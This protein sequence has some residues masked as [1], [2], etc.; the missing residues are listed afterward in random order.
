MRRRALPVAL[1]LAAWALT[2]KP[3]VADAQTCERPDFLEAIP[4]DGATDV[5]PNA[6]LFARY[7]TSAEYRD[8]DI[9]L[10]HVGGETTLLG[11]EYSPSEG[12]LSVTPELLA[13]GEYRVKWPEL[14]GRGG[15]ATFTVGDRLDT[16]APRFTGILDVTWDVQRRRDSCTDSV[17]DRYVFDLGLGAATDDGGT[18]LLRLVVFQTDGPGIGGAKPVLTQAFPEDDRVRVTL[19]VR[20]GTGRI[21]FAAVVL[22]ALDRASASGDRQTC[23]DTVAPPFFYGCRL[24][25]GKRAPPPG[26][27][28]LGLLALCA[29]RRRP[30]TRT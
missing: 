9:E 30:S 10:A 7:R 28:L 3:G 25:S 29:A 18:D 16:D 24:A 12:L 19:G 21:C 15:E 6:R 1:A 17:E 22:D 2:Q 26:V 8:E 20:E 27:L 14:R 5:P 4:P 23:V 13:G 11:G